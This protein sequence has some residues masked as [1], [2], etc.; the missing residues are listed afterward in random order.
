[1]LEYQ[2]TILTPLPVEGILTDN[3]DTL[4]PN[5]YMGDTST[6]IAVP[7]GSPSSLEV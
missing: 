4:S 2:D 5:V 3:K 6:E 7:A 1:V